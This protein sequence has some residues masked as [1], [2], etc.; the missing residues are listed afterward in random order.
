MI[1]FW[2]SLAVALAVIEITTTQLVSIWLAIGA[3][4]CAIVKGIFP[5]IAVGWQILIFIVVSG[6][7]LIATRPLVKKLLTK[8]GENHKTNLELVVGKEA[9]VVEEINN[10]LGKG[11]VKH[12]GL[13]WSAR[14]DDD[15]EIPVDEI[16]II[17]EIS[18]NKA[19]VERKG[20]HL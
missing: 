6:G 1:W 8:R 3:A 17:K 19:I 20:E 11:A 5:G 14:S 9:I 10:I 2:L 18:G 12:N 16:I 15:S 4:V 13:V 7:L